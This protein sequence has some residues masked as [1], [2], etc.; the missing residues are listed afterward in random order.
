MKSHV[1]AI[2]AGLASAGVMG[3]VAAQPT[4]TERN[5]EVVRQHLETMS[6]GEWRQAAEYF[7][8]DVRHH[9]GV[10][11]DGKQRIVDGKTRLAE[12]L[13][14]IFGTFPDWKMEILDIVGEGE[15]VVVRCR[16]SGTHNGVAKRPVNGGLLMNA[17]AT[18]KRFEVQHIHW[19]R[20]RSGKITDHFTNRD[21]LGMTQQ[22]GLLPSM[23]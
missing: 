6:R 12:N 20:L 7:A 15:T 5:K 18:G 3:L 17:P 11:Q 16:V 10:W 21:D 13:A 22:L 4:E 2:M 14:D 1:V 8:D 19:Y 9:L 23:R